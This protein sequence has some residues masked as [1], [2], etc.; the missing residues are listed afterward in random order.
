MEGKL[1]E[2]RA[3]K[4]RQK[5]CRGCREMIALVAKTCGNWTRVAIC[6]MDPTG[7]PPLHVTAAGISSWQSLGHVPVRGSRGSEC[8]MLPASS[9]GQSL[10]F[11]D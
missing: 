4:E 9:V 6:T 2:G 10:C 1:P 7:T 11:M 3:E 8:A 5:A